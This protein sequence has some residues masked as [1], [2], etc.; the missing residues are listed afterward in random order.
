MVYKTLYLW[1]IGTL[2][3]FTLTPYPWCIESITH[4]I[5]SHHPRYIGPISQVYWPPT[6]GMLNFLPMLLLMLFNPQPIVYQTFYPWYIGPPIRGIVTTLP[7]LFW[8]LP[9]V[10]QR[11]CQWYIKP[12]IHVIFNP[13]PWLFGF[14][15]TMVCKTLHLWYI[16][17]PYPWYYEP[18]IHGISNLLSKVCRTPILGILT[19]YP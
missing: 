6:H 15:L 7:M 11:T 4:G 16:G 9:V 18:L 2:I 8:P 12:P 1:N 14:P 10:Y 3:H 19:P 5:L 13:Y 17:F